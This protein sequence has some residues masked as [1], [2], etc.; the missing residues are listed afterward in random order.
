VNWNLRYASDSAKE[1]VWAQLEK[2]F[3]TSV[4]GWVKTARWLGPVD[5]P[6]DQVDFS[7]KKSW[8]AAKEQWLVEKKKKKIKKG[9][10]KPLILVG[11]PNNKKYMIVDGHH[12]DMAYE[13]MGM[14]VRAFV[15]RVS[16]DQGPWDTFHSKQLPKDPEGK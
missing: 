13:Q 5:V 16:K 6:L 4:M 9:K 10:R 11:T 12:R 2:S 3:P 8:T 7:N 14:P 1:K 15:A